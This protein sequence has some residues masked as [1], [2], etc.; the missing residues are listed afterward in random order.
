[1][2][3]NLSLSRHVT[4]TGFE[5]GVCVQS[6]AVL[7]PAT[8]AAPLSDAS[9]P[10]RTWCSQSNSLMVGRSILLPICAADEEHN[11]V[12]NLGTRKR[13]WSSSASHIFLT[14]TEFTKVFIDYELMEPSYLNWILTE[15]EMYN[16]RRTRVE[17]NEEER[18]TQLSGFWE[19]PDES[20]SKVMMGFYERRWR[21]SVVKQTS[22]W[23]WSNICRM[24]NSLSYFRL[25]DFDQ[26]R[27]YQYSNFLT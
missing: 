11:T 27:L 19:V 8:T 26:I 17:E 5:N 18:E 24:S 20:W 12:T 4:Q 23:S 3:F 22:C 15:S 13:H 14:S 7:H 2:F 16:G 9:A 1:M 10:C 25:F 21:S 6:S